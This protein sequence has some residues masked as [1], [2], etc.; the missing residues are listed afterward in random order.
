MQAQIGATFSQ[1]FQFHDRM[2]LPNGIV[3]Q[4]LS[5]VALV[6]WRVPDVPKRLANHGDN[7]RSAH[8]E[9]SSRLTVQGESRP[10]PAKDS[11]ANCTPLRFCWHFNN[12]VTRHVAGRILQRQMK[13][14][15]CFDFHSNNAASKSVPVVSNPGAL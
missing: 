6:F 10:R 4:I 13:V 9:F 12:Y 3:R 7:R 8:C 5:T 11:L 15:V 1:R 14:A 2:N